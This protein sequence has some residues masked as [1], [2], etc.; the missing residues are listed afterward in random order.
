MRLKASASRTAYHTSRDLRSIGHSYG[1]KNSPERKIHR[2]KK[3]IRALRTACHT[4]RDLRSI[5]HRYTREV[6]NQ[7]TAE[8][9]E[10]CDSFTF[11][12]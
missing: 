3:F 1:K 10:L 7:L 11:V 8:P 5:G 2:E 12:V 9:H 6:K 4:S